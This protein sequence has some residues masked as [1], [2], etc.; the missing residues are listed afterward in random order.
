MPPDS[1]LRNQSDSDSRYSNWNHNEDNE[2]KEKVKLVVGN[3]KSILTT[4]LKTSGA[5]QNRNK[6][7]DKNLIWNDYSIDNRDNACKGEEFFLSQMQNF[8]D[9]MDKDNP[10]Q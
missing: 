1:D 8:E 4:R 5:L 3:N 7:K 10:L 2:L 9:F 6:K